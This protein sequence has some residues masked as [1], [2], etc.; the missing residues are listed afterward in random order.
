M[1]WALLTKQTLS[2]EVG[3]SVNPDKT[4]LVVFTRQR[5]SRVSLNHIFLGLH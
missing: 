3:L 2:N 4:E 5:N 1:Q